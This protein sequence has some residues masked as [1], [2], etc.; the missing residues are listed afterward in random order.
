[1]MKRGFSLKFILISLISIALITGSITLQNIIN[2]NDTKETSYMI[3]TYI[4][5]GPA[6]YAKVSF[7]PI[8]G[9]IIALKVRDGD[10]PTYEFVIPPN[11]TGILAVNYYSDMNDL[12]SRELGVIGGINPLKIDIQKNKFDRYIFDVKIMVLNYTIENIHNVT[13]YYL[14]D[15]HKLDKGVYLLP[16]P[17]TMFQAILVVGEQPYLGSFPWDNKIYM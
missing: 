17:S 13:V 7:N 16:F 1:M 5:N 12:T 4:G 9:F 10:L 11:S 2:T 14:I 15:T 3:N 6:I 8:H